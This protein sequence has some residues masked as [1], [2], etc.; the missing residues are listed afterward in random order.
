[1]GI[2]G[3]LIKSLITLVS[4][5]NMRASNAIIMTVIAEKMRVKCVILLM[6]LTTA[7]GNIFMYLNRNFTSS[8][9]K[10]NI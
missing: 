3:E 2:T 8:P 4:S 7:T 6:C 10:T 1:M 5:I 9:Y